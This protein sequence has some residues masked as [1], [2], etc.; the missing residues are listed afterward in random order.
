MASSSSTKTNKKQKC[1]PPVAPQEAPTF[2][3]ARVELYNT[4]NAWT[5]GRVL[6]PCTIPADARKV[7]GS[8][9]VVTYFH[10][11]AV[12]H[13]NSRAP[14]RIWFKK[15]VGGATQGPKDAFIG[16]VRLV[17]PASDFIPRVGDILMG[18]V[19]EPLKVR[20]DDNDEEEHDEEHGRR[21]TR[22]SKFLYWF[23]GAGHLRLLF[24]LVCSGTTHT[25]LELA[26]ELRTASS[27]SS[28]SSATVNFAQIR[29]PK[30][31]VV[32]ATGSGGGDDTWALARLI[33][34]GNVEVFA[35]EHT[36]TGT[37][38]ATDDGTP[39]PVPRMNLSCAPLQFVYSCSKFFKDDSIWARF[40]TLVP[41][42]EEPEEDN[43]ED[44]EEEE[45]VDHNRHEQ[46][47]PT[48]TTGGARTP[49]SPVYAP[50][51]PAYAPASPAY[52]PSSP[53]YD[54]ST[55]PYDPSTPPY[56]PSTPPP[57]SPPYDPSTSPP[58]SCTT[59]NYD[60]D[61]GEETG[62]AYDP[63]DAAAATVVVSPQQFDIETLRS[64][65][66]EVAEVRRGQK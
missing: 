10:G 66:R 52:A 21:K 11:I 60:Y 50:A 64:I 28:S 46:Q 48:T 12:E 65:L 1:E 58:P 35:A 26:R 63:T 62:P 53:L 13:V 59:T 39:P 41:D 3:T 49:E 54:P 2:D 61:V 40:K 31:Q 29:K 7:V 23:A 33:L 9:E 57:S 37:A 36:G 56:D 22:S 5:F 30:P 19:S 27:S 38:T 42:A 55:P 8:K 6:R 4:L 24:D 18:K 43:E 25:E 51:S 16:P 47:R 34:F 45:D 17:A 44:D 32:A 14:K 20:H 15:H